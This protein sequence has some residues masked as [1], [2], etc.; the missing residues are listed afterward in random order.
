MSESADTVGDALPAGRSHWDRLPAELRSAVLDEAGHFTRFINGALLPA[1]LRSLRPTAVESVWK[2]A[3]ACDWQ[4]D[5]CLLPWANPRSVCFLPTHTRTMFARLKTGGF[6][7]PVVLRIVALQSRWPDL[8]DESNIMEVLLLA[9]TYDV[10]WYLRDAIDER[11]LALPD[12]ATIEAAAVMGHLDCFKFLAERMPDQSWQKT[13]LADAVQSGKLDFIV[14]VSEN[15]ACELTDDEVDF[16][17]DDGH[18]GIVKWLVETRN[19]SCS[20]YAITESAINGHYDTVVYLFER[21]PRRFSQYYGFLQVKNAKL[22]RWLH[23]RG[24]IARFDELLL[25]QAEKGS[26]A[27]L[28]ASLELSARPLPQ[29]ALETAC[30]YGRFALIPWILQQP[31]I[32]ITDVALDLAVGRNCTST[33]TAIVRH[34]RNVLGPLAAAIVK[35]RKAEL[36]EWLCVRHPSVLRQQLLDL[37]VGYGS[38]ECVAYLVGDKLDFEW[39]AAAALGTIKPDTDNAVVAV[40]TSRFGDLSVSDS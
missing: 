21:F 34:D 32:R 5:L 23:A 20:D 11:K 28:Q 40:L 39:D 25:K 26:L 4:G 17:A 6:C 12:K 33:L 27:S 1:E 31:G 35:A 14:W 13:I 22:L 9:A 2:D 30:Q 19:A 24:F 10:M 18:L 36:L 16:A 29:R 7:D 8:V 15:F 37:A 38:A 3:M